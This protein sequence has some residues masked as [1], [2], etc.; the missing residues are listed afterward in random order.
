MNLIAD[1]DIACELIESV[2]YTASA[3]ALRDVGRT[4]FLFGPD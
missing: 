3:D 1:A 4:A 2:L